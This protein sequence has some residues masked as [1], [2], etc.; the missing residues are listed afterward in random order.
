MKNLNSREIAN[1]LHSSV[2]ESFPFDRL[3][4]QPGRK[5]RNITASEDFSAQQHHKP[6]SH[7]RDDRSFTQS[8][9]GRR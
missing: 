8:L 1:H 4:H 2:N 9:W 7:L 5:V 3:M 6:E